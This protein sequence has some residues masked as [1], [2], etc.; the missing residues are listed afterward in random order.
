[1]GHRGY[2]LLEVLVVMVILGVMSGFIIL[3]LR[4]NPEGAR[5]SEAADRI[6][7]LVQLQC[8]EA[9]LGNRTM[10]MRL[11]DSGY[12]FEVAN[13]SGW[14]D[15]GKDVFRSRT[16]PVPLAARLSIDGR[17]D[18]MGTAGD[19]FIYCLPTGE[20]TPFELELSTRNGSR[21]AVR[22]T[23][24]GIVESRGGQG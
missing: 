24:G 3:S 14:E 17:A 13:R 2:T 19:N 21:A 8:E 10:R 23:A 11:D 12:R 7:A 22:A 15:H 20:L 18:A 6:A 16:W 1:M 9:L 5:L 4:G